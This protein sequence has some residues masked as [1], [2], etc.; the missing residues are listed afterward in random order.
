LTAGFIGLAA[1]VVGAFLIIKNWGDMSTWQKI[2]G[3]IG[4]A[5]AAIL[6]LALAFGVFHSAW[7]F[8]I[9]AAGIV[10]G[11]AAVVA[12]I[13]TV[14][15]DLPKTDTSSAQS[16]GIDSNTMEIANSMG[17]SEY[18]SGT[19]AT[20]TSATNTQS[21]SNATYTAT[22]SALR[23]WWGGQNAKGDIPKLQEA[24]ATGMYE[25]V[26]NVAGT[27]GNKWSKV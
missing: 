11:I 26:T 27:R 5:T 9:A 8:G 4:V 12:S 14:K 21:V 10:A 3:I 22:M 25:A 7:S 24:N 23:D 2:I 1:A 16:I 6:G 15:K 13:A 19:S 17:L 20:G 18:L